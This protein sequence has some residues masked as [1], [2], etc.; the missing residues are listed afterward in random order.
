M[1]PDAL[2]PGIVFATKYELTKRECNVLIHF[3][4]NP[5]TTAEV[6]EKSGIEK[7]TLYSIIQ[8]LKLKKILVLK[9]KDK[10]RFNLYEMNPEVLQ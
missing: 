10:D 1:N 6:L 4:E 7:K 9:D 5:C 2:I 8:R 3:L